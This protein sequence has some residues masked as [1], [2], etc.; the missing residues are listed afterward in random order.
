MKKPTER[1]IVLNQME[2]L[3]GI[4]ISYGTQNTSEADMKKYIREDG[5][6]AVLYSSS[7]GSGW[8]HS[9]NIPELVFDP[10]VVEMVLKQ[11]PK[12]KIIDYCKST[13]GADIYYGN[14]MILGEVDTLSIAWI[15]QGEEF[16][17]REYDGSESVELKKDFQWFTA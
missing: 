16:E 4:P 6:V 10:V 14:A 9:H 17:I 7:Y 3:F 8:Y 2:K 11:E 15:D 5:K 1:E 13:Y 12:E